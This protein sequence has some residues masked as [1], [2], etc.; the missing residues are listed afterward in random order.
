[1]KKE[2]TNE[3]SEYRM[4]K[5]YLLLIPT[6]THKLPKTTQKNTIVVLL[7]KVS[8]DKQKK[9]SQHKHTIIPTNTSPKEEQQNEF[10]NEQSTDQKIEPT[11]RK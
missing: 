2:Q 10:S 3:T 11:L 4:I 7:A 8:T 5:F 1:M 6:E 9:F